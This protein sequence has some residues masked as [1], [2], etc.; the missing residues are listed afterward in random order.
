MVTVDVQDRGARG[1]CLAVCSPV[2]VT[3]AVPPQ[4]SVAR[5]SPRRAQRLPGCPGPRLPG[6]PRLPPS[7]AALRCGL[8]PAVAARCPVYK[9]ASKIKTENHRTCMFL[10]LSTGERSNLKWDIHAVRL[11]GAGRGVG[12]PDEQRRQNAC[13]SWA[14]LSSHSSGG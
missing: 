14:L 3:G 13:K 8:N 9:Q 11:L 10:L 5:P 6:C 1:G 7:H 12:N 2:L 4:G